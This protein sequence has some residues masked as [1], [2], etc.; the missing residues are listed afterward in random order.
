MTPTVTVLGGGSWGP[1]LALHLAGLGRRVVLWARNA[2]L[3]RTIGA[4]REHPLHA[5]VRFPDCLET[6]DDLASAC[7]QARVVLFACPSHALRAVADRAR[8]HL[9]GRPMAVTTT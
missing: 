8:P 5:G 1:A 7:G 3:V 6:S 9:V 4:T 2:E